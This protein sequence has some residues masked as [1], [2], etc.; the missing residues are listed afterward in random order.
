MFQR[1]NVILA[2]ADARQAL[3]TCPGARKTVENLPD[4]FQRCRDTVIQ[5]FAQTI[6]DPVTVKRHSTGKAMRLGQNR[7]AQITDALARV[8]MAVGQQTNIF[9]L[10][11]VSG[12]D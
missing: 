9:C 3:A 7:L 6:P 4:M 2:P 5:P 1:N 10:M 8:I 12:Q 11:D